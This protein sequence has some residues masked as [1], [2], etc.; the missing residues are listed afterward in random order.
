MKTRDVGAFRICWAA[1]VVAAVA[2]VTTAT[3]EPSPARVLAEFSGA[4]RCDGHFVSNGSP[5]ASTMVFN[6]SEQVGALVLHHDDAPPNAY[7]AIELWTFDKAGGLS[8]TIADGF[9]GVRRL[10]SPGWEGDVLTWTRLQ[11]GRPVERFAYAR[12]GPGRIRVEWSVSRDGTTFQLG[13]TLDCKR[14]KS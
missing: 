5:I 12:R 13:D 9:S 14:S 2:T 11:E 3:A 1:A 6:W 10:V 7:H 4:W 8:A